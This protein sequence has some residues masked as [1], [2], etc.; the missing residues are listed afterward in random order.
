MTD[1]KVGDRSPYCVRLAA[2][3][4]RV[5]GVVGALAQARRGVA[6]VEFALSASLLLGLLVPVADLGIAF[7][8][9]HQVQQAVQAGA[10]YAAAHPWHKDSP[11]AITNAV[12]AASRLSGIAATPAPYQACGCPSGDAVT[13][14]SCGSTCSNSEI[15]GYYVVVNAQLS[16]RPKLPYS[17]LG[18]SVTLAAQSTV[19]IR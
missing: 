14:A 10:Q 16:Y 5:A 15:A 12:L 6:A 9:R 7:S 19:R 4:R 18:E 1:A 13:M 3:A 2:A 17:T 11:T 8:Q